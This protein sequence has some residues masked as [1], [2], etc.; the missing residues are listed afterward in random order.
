MSTRTNP[1]RAAR[2]TKAKIATV[3]GAGN[4]GDI[5]EDVVGLH[6]AIFGGDFPGDTI[7]PRLYLVPREAR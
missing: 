2:R 5:P 4:Y 3:Y 7:I 6:R 1:R